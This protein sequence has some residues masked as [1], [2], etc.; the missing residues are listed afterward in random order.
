MEAI[1]L[2]QLNLLIKETINLS[3]DQY[4][5]IIAE[6][7]QISVNSS[8]HA[9]LQLIEKSTDDNKIKASIRA[10]IWANKFQII[11][12]Y[13]N[14]LTG[15]ELKNGIKILVKAEVNFHEVYG[16]SL[17]IHDIDPTYTIGELEQ[18]KQKIIQQLEN[19]GI[20]DMNKKLAFPIAPQKIAIISSST[21]AG[22]DDFIN[23]LESNKFNFKFEYKLFQAIMQGEK[24]E[25]SIINALDKIF[26]EIENFD[27]VVIIRGGGSKLDLSAFDSYE[28]ASNIAQF[29]LPIIT[30][31][32][33][34]RDLS[35][36]D[37]VA[38]KSLKTPTATA[39]FLVQK[40]LEFD[41]LIKNKFAYLQ[42]II[43]NMI[44]SQQKII[45]QKQIQLKSVTINNF[46]VQDAYL[47]H[48]QQKIIA[49]SEK[50]F[51]KNYKKIAILQEHLKMSVSSKIWYENTKIDKMKV[52]ISDSTKIFFHKASNKLN[53]IQNKI[54]KSD[55]QHILNMG[56][57]LTSKN[58]KIITS[59]KDLK[60]GD[61][62]TTLFKDG[63]IDSEIS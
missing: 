12:A 17:I 36:A 61:K 58:K 31:I 18:Q 8:G 37:I 49:A 2:S 57:T 5:L 25:K 16:L 35:V 23:H 24:T 53:I 55:P 19:D 11:S 27:V 62:I 43:Y 32:G 45:T 56:Y 28:I 51:A 15:S 20:A 52:K 44:N 6:I 50:L 14:Q 22:L 21:A 42:D 13:F 40:L 54:Q 26:N 3:F 46:F 39:D 47:K 63:Y 29:P 34:H 41:I 7:N 30:G 48:L 9:Y 60:K 33:H 59:V 10:I 4:Y 1:S 38:Y